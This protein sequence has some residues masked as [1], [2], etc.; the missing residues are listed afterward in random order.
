MRT[1]H[2]KIAC[3]QEQI[4]RLRIGLQNLMQA[5]DQD[6]IECAFAITLSALGATAG[7]MSLVGT[8]E[9]TFA[10]PGTVFTAAT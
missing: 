1:P 10:A 9:S 2:A 7:L 5:E 8:L 4:L 6:L 3:L